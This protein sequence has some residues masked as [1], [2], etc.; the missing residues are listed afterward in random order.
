MNKSE[1]L[2]ILQEQL[3]G[4]VPSNE[5]YS[6]LHYYDEYID[7]EV[8]SGKSVEEVMD[9]LGDPRLI[10]KTII[11]ADEVS[12]RGNSYQEEAD[13]SRSDSYTGYSERTSSETDPQR[14]YY[15]EDDETSPKIHRLDLTTWY[16][17]ALLILAAAAVIFLVVTLVSA[18]LPVIIVVVLVCV[19]M[20]L[21]RKKR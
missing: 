14:S 15:Q 5:I 6:N 18:L 4:E 17:K 13:Y 21:F 11:D 1:F 2:A 8:A 7:R 9:L 20:A 10:A 19:I 3:E 12:V 16:G